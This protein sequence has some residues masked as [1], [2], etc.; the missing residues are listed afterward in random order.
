M[1]MVCFDQHSGRMGFHPGGR[2]VRALF[3]DMPLFVVFLFSFSLVLLSPSPSFPSWNDSGCWEESCVTTGLVEQA[4]QQVQW[5][6]P[7][8]NG[9]TTS[10]FT[11][12][13]AIRCYVNSS[14]WLVDHA[15][16]QC[17][18]PLPRATECV[19]MGLS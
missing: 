16:D 19:E 4:A 18:R 10:F 1:S 7:G 17:C 15:S 12:P 11:A 14:K 13:K 5:L 9:T 8:L 6:L 3:R 2:P